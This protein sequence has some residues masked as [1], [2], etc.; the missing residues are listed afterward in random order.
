[1]FDRQHHLCRQVLLDEGRGVVV[2]AP[3][4]TGKTRFVQQVLHD[5]AEV[6]VTEMLV[7]TR[8]AQGLPLG[9]VAALLPSDTAAPAEP[10]D[11]FRVVRSALEQR[12]AERPLIVAIDDA[13]LVDPLSAALLHHLAAAAGVRL[14]VAVRTGEPVEDAIT[15]L[16][17]DG[18]AQRLD[19]QPLGPRDVAALLRAVLDGEIDAASAHRL[20]LVTGGNPLYLH[21][22]VNEAQRVGTLEVRSRRVALAWRRAGSVPAFG[23]SSSYDWPRWTTRSVTS[24]RSSQSVTS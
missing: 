22:I 3:V 6:A 4:G 14:L 5:L 11:L 8:S 17:R 23:S 24:W 12:A 1:M 15:A 20:W 2:V 16:W 21:E 9:A 13:H 18:F 10:I 7:A 19:V